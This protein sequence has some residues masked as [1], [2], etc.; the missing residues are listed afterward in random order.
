M[1]QFADGCN[2]GCEY[3]VK[4]FLTAADFRAEAALYAACR[5]FL[6]RGVEHH[7]S[8]GT[9]ACDDGRTS[10]Q[11]A[12]RHLGDAAARFLPQVE[13]VCGDARDPAGAPLPPCIVM[14]KGES[15]QDW[16]NRAEPDLFMAVAVWPQCCPCIACSWWSTNV[17][18]M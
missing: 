14:E 1:V 17:I 8:V 18:L 2:D 4:F 16:S 13:A 10:G 3:A 15:L 9:V 7:G 12:M 5:P 11:A 6:F